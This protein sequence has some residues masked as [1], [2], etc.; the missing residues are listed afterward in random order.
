MLKYNKNINKIGLIQIQTRYQEDL[1][2]FHPMYT[3]ELAN[4]VE[5]LRY[6]PNI[7]ENLLFVAHTGQACI[8]RMSKGRRSQMP[9][10]NILKYSTQKTMEE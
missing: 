7:G 6:Q 10:S 4:F 3:G 9:S 5:Q 2:M 1:T 8:K